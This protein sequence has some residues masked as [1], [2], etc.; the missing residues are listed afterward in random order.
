M[1][2]TDKNSFTGDCLTV[3]IS[4]NIGQALDAIGSLGS[5]EFAGG[6]SGD[7]SQ[8]TYVKLNELQK[9]LDEWTK[10]YNNEIPGFLLGWFFYFF[11]NPEFH[12]P[13]DFSPRLSRVF[14]AFYADIFCNA[15]PLC[16]LLKF[17]IFSCLYVLL[18]AIYISV[19]S[20][21]AGLRIL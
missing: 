19:L 12:N 17:I 9:D 18:K 10:Y 15:L 21:R 5:D 8:K 3:T 2:V 7:I 4:H 6:L 16:N 14:A 13:V 1:V 11:I 20:L